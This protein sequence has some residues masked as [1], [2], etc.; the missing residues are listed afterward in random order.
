[1]AT[2]DLNGASAAPGLASAARELI[3]KLSSINDA[4]Y[5]FS[6]ASCE[7]Y[8]TA[9]VA[10]VTKTCG[11]DQKRWLFPEC[12]YHL[13]KTQAKDGSWDYHPQT[14]V[15]GVLGTGAALLALLKH[16]KSPL[17]IK[18]VS[19]D[20]LRK[21]IAMG[22][23]SLRAQLQD[24][25]DVQRTNHIGVEIVTPALLAYL[26]EEDPEMRFQFPRKRSSKRCTRQNYPILS[27]NIIRTKG[28]DGRPF[29]G[30]FYQ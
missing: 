29:I 2:K 11:D 20:E 8:D 24:W 5:S 17:Q 4:K 10:M 21:R 27:Q 1:M 6:T 15:P 23:K 3:R 26:E 19:A 7:T 13:L 14:K 28:F 30:S 16:L 18:D 25:D 12:F 22:S 9:W